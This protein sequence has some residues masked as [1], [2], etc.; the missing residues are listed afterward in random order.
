MEKMLVYIGKHECFPLLLVNGPRHEKTCLRGFANNKGA[1]QPAHQR[2][3]IS[4]FII[5]LLKSIISRLATSE[6][7]LFYLVSVAEETGLSL[8]LSEIPK[9][10][11]LTLWPKY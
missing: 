3:L 10:G 4:A 9:T 1:D 7:S 2:I 11:F 8:A 6:I 5:H